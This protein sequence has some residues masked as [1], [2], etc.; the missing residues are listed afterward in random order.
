MARLAAGCF[1]PSPIL[2]MTIELQ[3]VRLAVGFSSAIPRATSDD[4]NSP[5][6][7]GDLP[8]DDSDADDEPFDES[9]FDDDFNDDFEEGVDEELEQDIESLPE[10]PSIDGGDEDLDTDEDVDG[11][12]DVD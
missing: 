11:A 9:D 5:R 1:R 6:P 2:C 3:S 10:N 8:T 4:P 12:D 7:R